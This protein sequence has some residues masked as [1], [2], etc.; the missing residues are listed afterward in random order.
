MTA[1]TA[2]PALAIALLF[3]IQSAAAEDQGVWA[4][5]PNGWSNHVQSGFGCPP[6]LA[7]G[8]NTG[9]GTIY[10]SLTLRTVIIG[11]ERQPPGAQ[12]GCEYDGGGSWATVELVRLAPGESASSRF[13]AMRGRIVAKYSNAQRDRDSLNWL[14]KS[15]TGGRTYI[16]A[17]RTIGDQR[18]SVVVLGGD[19]AGWMITLI[20]YSQSNEST[21]VQ[22]G[23]LSN[24]QR[25]ASSRTRR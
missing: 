16:A 19:V 24:W 21:G 11:S 7:G 8:H 14:P 22:L 6:G 23:A 20:Q 4:D 25:V 10:P 18:A 17:Y 12:A 3:L 5:G 15:P 9:S 2:S 13:D 1:R